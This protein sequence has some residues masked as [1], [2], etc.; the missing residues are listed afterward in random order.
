M[1]RCHTDAHRELGIALVII[2][3][4]VVV[5]VAAA[6]AAAVGA[7]AT[8]LHARQLMLRN[9]VAQALLDVANAATSVTFVRIKPP[10]S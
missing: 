5:A 4:V 9:D 6:A 3:V 2:V 10:S 8:S 1:S 7:V